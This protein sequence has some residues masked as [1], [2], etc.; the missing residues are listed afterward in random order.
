MKSYG[1]KSQAHAGLSKPAH[2]GARVNWN[3]ITHVELQVCHGARCMSGTHIP[4]A[5]IIANLLD[6][7]TVGEILVQYPT[8]SRSD[9]EIVR[10]WLVD[11]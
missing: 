10:Q 8:L 3:D 5:V 7:M 1:G 2:S 6:E 11:T 4:I 9:V